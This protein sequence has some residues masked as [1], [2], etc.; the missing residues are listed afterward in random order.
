MFYLIYLVHSNVYYLHS[1]HTLSVTISFSVW[2]GIWLKSITTI[3]AI[4]CMPENNE[5]S[6]KQ[7]L[8]TL[9]LF[10]P[11]AIQYCSMGV[12]KSSW[13]VTEIQTF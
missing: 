7:A 1:H 10:T 9:L 8:F 6:N 12:G 11:T 5:V 2:L 4:T 3:S 13:T